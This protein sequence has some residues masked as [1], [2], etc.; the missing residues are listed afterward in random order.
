MYRPRGPGDMVFPYLKAIALSAPVIQRNNQ[1]G[2]PFPLIFGW[3]PMREIDVDPEFP[4]FV[5]LPQNSLEGRH[6]SYI[7]ANETSELICR[8]SV[9]RHAQSFW[10]HVLFKNSHNFLSLDN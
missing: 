5:V 8:N 2:K 6:G 10:M 7:L 3:R 1:G 9:F 4:G